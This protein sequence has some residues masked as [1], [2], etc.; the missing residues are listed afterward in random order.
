MSSTAHK[1]VSYYECYHKGNI[2]A[3]CFYYKLIGSSLWVYNRNTQEYM[4]AFFDSIKTAQ[5]NDISVRS[6]TEKYLLLRGI[7]KAPLFS[8]ATETTF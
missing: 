5:S 4:K 1:E 7:E 3:R 6:V 8:R 2:N